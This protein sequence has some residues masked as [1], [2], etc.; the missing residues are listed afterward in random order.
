M[1]TDVSG[2]GFAA[3]L[4]LR[5]LVRRAR[6]VAGS[7]TLALALKAWCAWVLLAV[8]VSTASAAALASTW[9]WLA[10]W[11]GYMAASDRLRAGSDI[12]RR[13]S[14]SAFDSAVES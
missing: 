12:R 6:P 1:A 10:S 9:P 14:G 13:L 8:A 7:V 2:R 11:K 5:V 3:A 4:M